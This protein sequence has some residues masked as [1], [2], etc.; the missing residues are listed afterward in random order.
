MIQ[1]IELIS[2]DNICSEI[3]T[4]LFSPSLAWPDWQNVICAPIVLCIR[5][6]TLERML[7]LTFGRLAYE[8]YLSIK[9]RSQTVAYSSIKFVAAVLESCPQS[10]L[11]MYI[12]FA[13]WPTRIEAVDT[14]STKF[15]KGSTGIL[16]VSLF[17]SMITLGW[18]LLLFIDA[19]QIKHFVA[20]QG[21]DDQIARFCFWGSWTH[22]KLYR[23]LHRFGGFIYHL[24]EIGVRIITW[25]LLVA[26]IG[27]YFIF[28]LVFSLILRL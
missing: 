23:S 7:T 10:M 18:T 9:N 17:M 21:H 4:N 28:F 2:I 3:N 1:V 19:D 24:S 11:Q 25:A 14:T 26:E 20:A 15:W 6:C 12:L 5:V 27:A 16:V 13:H 8:T 22:A